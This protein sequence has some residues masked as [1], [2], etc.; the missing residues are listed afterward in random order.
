MRSVSVVCLLITLCASTSAAAASQSHRR[1]AVVR[2]NQSVVEGS[3]P[4]LAHAP[5]GP[6]IPTARPAPLDRAYDNRYPNWGM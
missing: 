4:G 5:H 1:H 2:T 3:V 6:R